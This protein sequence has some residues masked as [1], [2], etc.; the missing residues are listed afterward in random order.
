MAPADTICKQFIPDPMPNIDGNCLEADGI[1]GG[2][3]HTHNQF[4]NKK[5]RDEEK[6]LNYHTSARP[7]S[8]VSSSK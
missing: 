4:C 1:N 8:T 6:S 7:L 3:T 5:K 2:D